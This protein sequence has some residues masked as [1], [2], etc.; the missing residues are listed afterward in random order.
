[1]TLAM[2]E[3]RDDLFGASAKQRIRELVAE[4]ER[5][6]S[7]EVM[8][9]V[10]PRSASYREAEWLLGTVFA[11]GWLAGSVPRA[12]TT[13]VPAAAHRRAPSTSRACAVTAR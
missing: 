10:H 6:S 9:A 3:R 1:M 12:R 11:L 13:S 5:A 8:V 4:L 2:R 7:A